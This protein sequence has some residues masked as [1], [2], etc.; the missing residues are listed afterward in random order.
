MLSNQF[1][2]PRSKSLVVFGSSIFALMAASCG[3]KNNTPEDKKSEAKIVGGQNA[4]ASSP[5][6]VTESTVGISTASLAEQGQTFCSGTLIAPKVV[7]TASHCFSNPDGSET[8]A[9]SKDPFVVVFS[10][11][12]SSAAKMVKVE[13]FKRHET[14]DHQLTVEKTRYSK[15]SDDIALVY[16]SEAAPSDKKPLGVPLQTDEIPKDIILAGY[17]TTGKLAK[18][19]AGLFVFLPSSKGVKI[20]TNEFIP[21]QIETLPDTGTLRFVKT[22][23]IEVFAG[24]KVMR[25]S[26]LKE[27][28]EG[29][30]PGDSGGPVYAQSAAIKK[31]F[32]VL[33]TGIVGGFDNNNDGKAD[34]GCVGENT[35]TDVRMYSNW[36]S[37]NMPK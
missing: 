10:N 9:S 1:S 14:Y 8:V 4:T 5:K 15:P 24:G 33:S 11:K 23:V 30:C 6:V 3:S 12:A 19:A 36:I 31:V 2:L 32:G 25:T 16:L 29:A 28:P 21:G 17:G 26:E 35:Y 20:N 22:Q 34:V 37:K 27:N 13:T 7:L 18:S